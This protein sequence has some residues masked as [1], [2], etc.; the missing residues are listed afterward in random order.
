MPSVLSRNWTAATS[1]D[2]LSVLLWIVRCVLHDLVDHGNSLI[3][4]FS[5]PVVTIVVASLV[6]RI[7]TPEMT[8]MPVTIAT[9][10]TVTKTIATVTIVTRTIVDIAG[11]APG[12]LLAA[13]KPMTVA[14]GLHLPGGMKRRGLQGT[15]IGEVAM[16]TEEALTLT[17]TVAGMTTTDAGTTAVGTRGKIATRTGP[18]GTPTGKADGRAEFGQW[19]PDIIRLRCGPRKGFRKAFWTCHLPRFASNRFL[20]YGKES[21]SSCISSSKDIPP[22]V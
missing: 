11:N 6:G 17:M 16:M 3:I 1:E 21:S 12:R 13:A 7:V 20:L 10:M 15:M 9:A 19:F 5:V 14:P 22:N 4:P 2:S 8:A 18:R